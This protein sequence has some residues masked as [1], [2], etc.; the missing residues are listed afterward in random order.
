MKA[1]LFDLDGVLYVGD[2][3]IEGAIET[4]LWCHDRKIT[5]LFVTNT[6]S[7]SR[8]AIVA[9]LSALGISTTAESILTP[10]V[11]T[12]QWLREQ[13]LNRLGLFVSEN[14][15]QEFEGFSL[16]ETEYDEVDAVII[17]DMG[18]GWDFSTL[19]RA[20]RLLMHP[21]H[22][23][24]VAL[25]LTRYWR[26]QDGLRLDAGAYVAALEYATGIKA[27]VLGKPAEKFY[28]AALHKLGVNTDE[29]VMIGDDIKGDIGGAQQAGIR[30]IMVRSGK[31]R[32]ADLQSGI[33]PYAIINSI[34]DLPA[35]WESNAN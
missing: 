20:F 24:L 32:E 14:T 22:P 25:G 17:G 8:A 13:Q 30:G 6:T 2:R 28:Q 12:V 21:Q 10:P 26:A 27:E 33:T 3:L 15:R 23:H 1:I 19:N 4:L 18:E 9:K 16:V 7:K 29:A 31:F 5:H 11:A 35:W 34:A